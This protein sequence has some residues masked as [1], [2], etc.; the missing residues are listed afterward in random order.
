MEKFFRPLE[1]AKGIHHTN[2]VFTPTAEELAYYKGLLTAMGEVERQGT[3]A[4]TCAGTMVDMAM[5]KM[6][7]QVLAP[8]RTI[9]T[10]M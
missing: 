3:A 8:A 6:A 4:V 1:T 7:Q 2:D 10:T 9:G 5:G